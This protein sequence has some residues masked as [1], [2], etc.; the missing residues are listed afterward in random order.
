ELADELAFLQLAREVEPAAAADTADLERALVALEP[1][2]D[3]DQRR[4][5]GIAAQVALDLAAL[6]RLLELGAQLERGGL[7][8]G[9]VGDL[10]RPQARDRIGLELLG[11]ALL[12][13]R[14]RFRLRLVLLLLA[15][16]LLGLLFLLL[17]GLLALLGLAFLLLAFL[18]LL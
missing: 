6:A 14:R 8:A 10:R 15:R 9:G 3:V 11:L 18:L 12:L 16:L 17:L 13:L 5:D 4:R 1:A 7:C 2:L